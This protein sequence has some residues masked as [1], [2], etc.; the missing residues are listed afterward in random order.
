MAKP[1]FEKHLLIIRLSAMGD[2]AMLVPV[3]HAF[4]KAN[5]EVKIAFLTK[6]FHKPIVA[7][8]PEV[9]CI[10]AEVQGRHKG[11]LGLWK[12]SRQLKASGITHVADMHQVMRS[13]I[14]RFFLRLPS[15]SLDKGRKAKKLQTAGNVKILSPLKTTI[16]RYQE[17]LE[18]LGFP[19]LIPESLSRPNASQ[20][21]Q[22]FV[23]N[24][25]RKWLGIAPFAAHLGKQYPADLM[26]V[27]I[28]ELTKAETYD[29]FLFGAPTE[30]DA[31]KKLAV[32]CK[33]VSIVAGQLSFEDQLNFIGQLDGMLS[34]DSGNAHL[35]AMYGVPT[36][37]LWGVTHPSIG[38]APFGQKENTLISDRNKYPGIPTSVYGNV[39]PAGY[40]DVMQTI[41]PD[42]V[43]QKIKKLL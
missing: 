22:S 33:Q 5:P 40:E 25:T 13:K 15:A 34:M 30:V 10:T 32:G 38:F 11:I 18:R 3:V 23:Q 28:Q 20:N 9:T 14:L 8:I 37:T 1:L 7:A 42:A 35:A 36:L 2:V 4:A 16:Q 26:K 6:A 24:S 27:V 17:V 29:L 31:L 19:K 41:H 12:L 39:V 21:V 43:I